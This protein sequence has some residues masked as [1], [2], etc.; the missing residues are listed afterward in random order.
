MRTFMLSVVGTTGLALL[1][2]L[3]LP[4]RAD[5]HHSHRSKTQTSQPRLATYEKQAAQSGQL[6]Y[7]PSTERYRSS[8]FFPK[9]PPARPAQD[10]VR[11]VTLYDNY[12]SPS[13]LMVPVGMTV[14]F[15]NRGKHQ[16]TT[17]ANW[18]WESGELKRGESFSLTFAR[19]GT[20]YYYCRHHRD[21]GGTI[22]VF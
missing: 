1:G 19:A 2:L 9:D 4:G 7:A 16:H 17:T 21:M 22:V 10:K 15:T 13:Y 18:V 8:Y 5:D 12:F 11:D 6:D 20:Y 14:R 3:A